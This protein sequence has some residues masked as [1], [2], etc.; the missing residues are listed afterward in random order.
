MV[1]AQASKGEARII[2]HG[3]VV[4]MDSRIDPEL[5]TLTTALKLI[6]KAE[7]TYEPLKN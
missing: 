2:G 1:G 5:S 4:G 3:H 7:A 6:E